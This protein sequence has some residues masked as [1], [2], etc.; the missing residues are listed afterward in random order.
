MQSGQIYTI[1]NIDDREA[2]YRYFFKEYDGTPA[3]WA[4]ANELK[5]APNPATHEYPFTVLKERKKGS[6]AEVYV[7]YLFYP[8]K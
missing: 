4:Y 1:T 6:R 5:S 3:G 2:P 8:D 7:K